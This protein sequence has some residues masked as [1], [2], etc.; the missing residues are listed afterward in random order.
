[1]SITE[2]N[3]SAV[4]A[5]I[6]KDCVAI[7]SDRR[8][9]VQARTVSCDFQRIFKNSD[10]VYVAIPG[11]GTDVQTVSQR[12][13]FRSNLY[14][15]REGREMSPATLLHMISSM[16]YEKRFGPYYVEPVVA[17]LDQEN[18]PFVG[19]MDLIGCENVPADFVVGGTA[20]EQLYGICESMWRPDMEPE[21]LFE[22]VSQCLLN[23]QDRDALSG[24]GAVVYVIEADKVT[25][26]TLKGRMD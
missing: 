24:W 16:M 1:M 10:K 5:M 26:R 19:N 23:A 20:S 11:L 2:Y 13:D 12:I 18:K 7:A 3:G 8:F 14:K 22:T 9:G 21:D 17:G 6:G 4:L 25:V 15:L